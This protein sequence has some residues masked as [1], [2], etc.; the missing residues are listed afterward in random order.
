[1]ITAHP[2][3]VAVALLVAA[4]GVACDDGADSAAPSTSRSSTTTSTS[5]TTTSTTV[6]PATEQD[7]RDCD[8][9]IEPYVR[10][11]GFPSGLPPLDPLEGEN[12]RFSGLEYDQAT[13]SNPSAHWGDLNGDGV[14]DRLVRVRGAH[15]GRRSDGILE[16]RRCE[17]Q[18]DQAQEQWPQGK[19]H[20]RESRTGG[21]ADTEHDERQDDEEDGDLPIAKAGR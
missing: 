5:A 19:A 1:M 11:A 13:V 20:D 2:A 10:R 8:R 4:A 17:P 15:L 16:N 3:I 18:D 12:L 14:D 7:I 6:L 9:T 21:V